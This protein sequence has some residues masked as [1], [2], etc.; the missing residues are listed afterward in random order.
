MEVL[1]FPISSGIIYAGE[2][3]GM[4]KFENRGDLLGDI[5]SAIGA[6]NISDQRLPVNRT[7]VLETVL[8]LESEDYPAEQWKD[9]AYYLT[10]SRGN[11]RTAEESKEDLCDR[12]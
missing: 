8:H 11:C 5:S 4:L 12:I 1:Q 3:N 6:G 7:R 10:G 2:A 9:A